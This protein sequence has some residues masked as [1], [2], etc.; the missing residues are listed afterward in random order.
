M[1]INDY[2]ELELIRLLQQ[3]G[4]KVFEQLLRSRKEEMEKNIKENISNPYLVRDKVYDI[5]NMYMAVNS[6]LDGILNA[7]QGIIDRQQLNQEI[8][9]EDKRKQEEVSKMEGK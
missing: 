2:E 4:W 3:P 7:I 9:E 1:Q 8:V 6:E 5:I